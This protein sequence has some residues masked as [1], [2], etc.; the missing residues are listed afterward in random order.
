MAK[1]K[2]DVIKEIT[3]NE[4]VVEIKETK[5]QQ[6]SIFDL[7]QELISIEYLIK[8]YTNIAKAND[9]MYNYKTDDIY[10]NA[11]EKIKKIELMRFTIIKELEKRII[12]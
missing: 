9:G 12:G 2:T 3:Q 11:M 6:K 7:N 1:K 10:Q 4:N 5:I 8:Y